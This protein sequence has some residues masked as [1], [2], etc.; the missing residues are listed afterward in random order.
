M[1]NNI[2]LPANV[3][4]KLFRNVYFFNGTAYAGKSTMVRLLAEKYDGIECGENYHDILQHLA[5]PEHQPNL[6]YF[7]TMKDWQEFIN[8]KPEVYKAWIDGVSQE[9][10]QLEII[11]L[12]QLVGQYPDKKIFVD[13][14]LSPEILHQ[15]SDYDH[16]AILLSPQ[17]MSVER[18]FD[19]SD[20]EKQFLLS[21]IDA[22][23]DPARTM[24]NFRD[25]LALINSPEN[26][27]SLAECGFYTNVRTEES[28]LEERMIEIEKHFGLKKLLLVP[29]RPADCSDR[30]AKEVRCYDLLDRL[31]IAY[32]RIDHEATMTMEAC[33]EVD[34]VLD[35]TICKN[36]LLCNRQCTDF[37][38]LMMPGNKPF[39]TKDLSHQIGTS[40]LSFAA[41]EY[42]EEFLDITPGS[43][44]VLGL[45]N[46]TNH[47]VQLL[48]DEDVLAGEL[49]G[50]HPCINTS[51]LRM[52]TADL[53]E[54]VI[55]AMEH[56][57]R[58]VVLPKYEE[59]E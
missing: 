18:F 32:D 26:Y 35:A 48:I 24:S 4:R 14:N 31:G 45:M 6:S 25:C 52:K 46:D 34:K 19:R 11:R 42:M 58:I 21:Q 15:I 51:S 37:Y 41:P 2:P 30:L 8:R 28:T 44:S 39:K 40:R 5:D 7:D 1:M 23:E 9:A 33:A 56:E 3:L 17:S 12:L 59:K 16:V 10:G 29:G 38:M 27:Q 55:P 22:A 43:L 53:M 36:L 20:P 47:R 13:T 50:C 49:I 57:P 54:L